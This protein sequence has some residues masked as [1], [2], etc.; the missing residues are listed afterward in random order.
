MKLSVILVFEINRISH[1]LWFSSFS[2]ETE[3]QDNR[4]LGKFSRT[5]QQIG[6]WDDGWAFLSVVVS[7][8]VERRRDHNI[9]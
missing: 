3:T 2:K 7:I 6:E 8:A 4:A 9:L 1:I 5:V